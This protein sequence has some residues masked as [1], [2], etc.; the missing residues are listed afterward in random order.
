MKYRRFQTTQ[1]DA[2]HETGLP[3]SLMQILFNEAV[4]KN[5]LVTGAGKSCS[6]H[7]KFGWLGRAGV[8]GDTSE[9]WL[10]VSF[11]AGCSVFLLFNN[12]LLEKFGHVTG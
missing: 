11:G 7:I 10:E 3:V 9:A 4:A 1:G 8:G 12:P 6:S 5:I 2:H